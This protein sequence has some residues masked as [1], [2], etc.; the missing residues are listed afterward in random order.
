MEKSDELNLAYSK[1][2]AITDAKSVIKDIASKISETFA[3][4]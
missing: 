1:I 4:C 3:S 2:V